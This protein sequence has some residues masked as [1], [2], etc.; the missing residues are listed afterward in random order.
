MMTK[1]KKTII[2]EMI[3]KGYQRRF[4]LLL[5]G[6]FFIGTVV[7]SIYLYLD[8]YR[9]LDT[10]YSAILSIITEIK[11]TLIIRSIKISAF[12]YILILAGIIILGVL[13][14][15]RIAGPLHRVKLFVRSIGEGKQ[16]AEIKFRQRDAINSF[17]ESLNK[18]AKSY[19]DRT[20]L[21]ISEIEQLKIAVAEIKSLTEKGED[22]EVAIQKALEI[23]SRIKKLLGTIRL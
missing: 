20:N 14:T 18:V 16:V 2:T 11:E 7:S 22:T 17:A 5:M 23:D 19:G 10:H 13:Y 9:P 4:I 1:G 8:I 12:F 21:L 6:V 3:K 15:H